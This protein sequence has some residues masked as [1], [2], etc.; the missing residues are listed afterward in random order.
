[1]AEQIIKSS[2][3]ISFQDLFRKMRSFY[4]YLLSRWLRICMVG[5]IGMAL[6]VTIAWLKTPEYQAVLSFSMEDDKSGGGLA[7][8]AAQF[9]VD[10]GSSQ[11]AFGGENIFALLESKKMTQQT[12][13]TKVNIDGRQKLLLNVYME[14]NELYKK[15]SSSQDPGLRKLYFPESQDPATYS[16]LQDSVLMLVTDDFQKNILKFEKADAKLNLYTITVTTTSEP[17]SANFCRELIKQA[18][19]FYVQVKTKRSAQVVDILQKRSDSMRTAYNHALAQKAGITD[20]NLN[21]AFQSATVGIQSKQT[22]ITVFST[23]YAELLKNLEIAKFNLLKETPVIQVLDEPM[24]PLKKVKLSRLYLGVG[25]G[26]VLVFFYI[27][28][29]GAKRAFAEPVKQTTEISQ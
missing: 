21:L 24:E 26:F 18:S 19:T 6:G 10:I 8:L 27:L 13:L 17:L 5:L 22:D 16:R 14:E 23:A 11:G 12:L 15:Y 29:L 3:E 28:Y 1:M 9:G 4:K 25:A 2:S 7:S 20:A